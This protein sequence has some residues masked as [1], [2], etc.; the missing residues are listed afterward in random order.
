MRTSPSDDG[1]R[2]AIACLSGALATNVD[3]RG[4]RA[5]PTGFCELP[6]LSKNCTTLPSPSRTAKVRLPLCPDL[7]MP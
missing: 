3:E 7:T 1:V 2:L 6:Y 5:S 4:A